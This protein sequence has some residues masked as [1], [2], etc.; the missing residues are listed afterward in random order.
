MTDT[1][2]SERCKWDFDESL[3]VKN[4]IYPFDFGWM[5]EVGLIFFVVVVRNIGLILEGC[6]NKL[7]KQ[8]S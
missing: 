7:S 4:I 6:S 8:K 1:I 3:R 2:E 5:G